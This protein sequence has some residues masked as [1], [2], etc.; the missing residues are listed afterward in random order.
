[1]NPVIV[2]VIPGEPR[3]TI[4][5]RALG[6]LTECL[7]SLPPALRP[8]ADD[9]RISINHDEGCPS[10]E[11]RVWTDCTCEDL[12]V[13]AIPISHEEAKVIAA[14]GD[15][16]MVGI[17]EVGAPPEEDGGPGGPVDPTVH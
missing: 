17:M 5:D 13:Q 7:E 10:C 4:A 2:F 8:E 1:M 3:E 9:L 12:L 16:D 11:S 6:L 15:Y 14:S